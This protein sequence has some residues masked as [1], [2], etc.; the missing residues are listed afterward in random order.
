MKTA[1][2]PSGVIRLGAIVLAVVLAGCTEGTSPGAE[3]PAASSAQAEALS[4]LGNLGYAPGDAAGAV[5]QAA[6]EMEGASTP[7][8]IRAALKLLAPKG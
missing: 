8:L 5:A 6:G 7:D 3:A 1:F 2:E 4:A